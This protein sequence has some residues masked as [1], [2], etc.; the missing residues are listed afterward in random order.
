MTYRPC[1]CPRYFCTR[2]LSSRSSTVEWGSG[3]VD[4]HNP[5]YVCFAQA[6]QLGVYSFLRIRLF[7]KSKYRSLTLYPVVRSITTCTLADFGCYVTRCTVDCFSATKLSALNPL[8]WAW[9]SLTMCVRLVMPCTVWQMISSSKRSL[10]EISLL[11]SRGCGFVL[12]KTCSVEPSLEVESNICGS[13]YYPIFAWH[14]AVVT[15]RT[16]FVFLT[17]ESISPI[18]GRIDFVRPTVHLQRVFLLNR[19]RLSPMEA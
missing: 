2:I 13:V 15:S 9:T 4:S 10:G 5:S 3:E 16:G 7:R 6:G 12:D 8:L 17:R 19:Y 1:L 14:N 18:S 11:P